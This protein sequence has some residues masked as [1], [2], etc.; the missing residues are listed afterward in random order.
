MADRR[1]HLGSPHDR[2]RHAKLGGR[3]A[4]W[5]PGRHFPSLTESMEIDE[6][7]E[8]HVRAKPI[9]AIL[10]AAATVAACSS[11][12]ESSP[13]STTSVPAAVTTT[14]PT[15]DAVPSSSSAPAT[16]EERIESEPLRTEAAATGFRIGAAVSAGLLRS[17]DAYRTAVAGHFTSLTP[18]NAMKWTVTRPAPDEWN[19]TDAD[20]LVD[21]AEAQSM[22][23]RGHTL[24]WGSVA[25]NG[26]PQWLRALEDPDLFRAAVFEGVTTQVERY[27]GRVHRWDVVNEPLAALGGELDPNLYLERLGPGY[28]GEVFRT[29]HAAD[30]DAELW[31]NEF[32]TEF[33]P[34]K[35]EGLVALVTE[36]VE[37]G[38]PIDGVGFQ[39]H[40]TVD[41]SLPDGAISSVMQ[42]IA[43][44]GLA[45]AVTEL[46]AP[47]GPNRDAPAQA[48]LYARVLEEC[49]AAGCEEVTVWGVSDAQ[50]WLDDAGTRESNPFLQAFDTPST[51]L[52][53][54]DDFRPKLAYDA[55]VEVLRTGS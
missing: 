14:S 16:G 41:V 27:R 40:L 15:A 10:V 43:D 21:F 39:T 8:R 35:A 51:P 30:P 4:T 32:G 33:L 13:P 18:E 53:L 22:E 36:L 19:W 28:I 54:D 2:I 37:D 47:M 20:F 25:G 45:V 23:V 49:R 9:A 48:D 26:V 34:D 7:G 11:G 42:R 1:K 6:R 24:A 44:L 5:R 3:P 17:D 55:L 31:L 50:T 52:L 12:G 29:A 46:D 38:V